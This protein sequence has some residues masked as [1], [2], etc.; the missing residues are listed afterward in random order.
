M[1]SMPFVKKEKKYCIGVSHLLNT[2]CCET[3]YLVNGK[4]LVAVDNADLAGVGKFDHM[5]LLNIDDV[6][7]GERDLD[8]VAFIVT[9]EDDALQTL[10][11]FPGTGGA[12]GPK[13]VGPVGGDNLKVDA[14]LVLVGDVCRNAIGK[15]N[16][17]MGEVRVL[18]VVV[19]GEHV[20]L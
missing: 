11:P 10:D 13:R 19:V 6:G 17:T 12:L 4:R 9:P 14:L 7:D 15:V 20:A 5:G 3:T 1:A 18:G 2:V 16:L 8:S